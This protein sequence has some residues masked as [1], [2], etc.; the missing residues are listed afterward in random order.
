MNQLPEM[1]C[2]FTQ[3][4]RLSGQMVKKI[5]EGVTER[6]FRVSACFLTGFKEGIGSR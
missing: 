5:F 1:V 2:D 3:R 6:H 4:S